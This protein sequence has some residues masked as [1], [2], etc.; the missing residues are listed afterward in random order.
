MKLSLI[1][2]PYLTHH[3][4]FLE[5]TK[6][7]S[8]IIETLKCILD[9][10]QTDEIPKKKLEE[11]QKL[12]SS[13]AP[14]TAE[15]KLLLGLCL[16]YGV[17]LEKNEKKA[18]E[19]FE[20]V[21]KQEH[22]AALYNLG[23]CY[24]DGI[25]VEQDSKQAVELYKCAAALEYPAAQNNLGYCYEK[26]K[27]IVCDNKQA[28]K[29]VELAA[30]SGFPT[31]LRNLGSYYENGEIVVQ[32]KK[33]AF[34][35]YVRAAE[36]EGGFPENLLNAARC[37]EDGVGV[38]KDKKRVFDYYMLAADR[39]SPKGY[40]ALSY[41]Y[42]SDTGVTTNAI[43][44]ILLLQ[45]LAKIGDKHA[46]SILL[47]HDPKDKK[48]KKIIEDFE[49]KSDEEA[50]QI[51]KKLNAE[52][53]GS[54]KAILGFFF[55]MGC[56]VKKDLKKA[57]EHYKIA[58]N[59]GENCNWDL[60]L[61]YRT[62]VQRGG[63]NNEL[64]EFYKQ[65]KISVDTEGPQTIVAGDDAAVET[66]TNSEQQTFNDEKTRKEN[67]LL[68]GYLYEYGAPDF[69]KN[70]R[71]SIEYY[72]KAKDIEDAYLNGKITCFTKDES[73][74][75]TYLNN[76]LVYYKPL[77]DLKAQVQAS[78]ASKALNYRIVNIV[79]EY[80]FEAPPVPIISHRL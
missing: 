8:L 33:R 36:A 64:L 23:K 78:D 68:L 62:Q 69:D 73:T 34:Y 7:D 76:K 41:Y 57:I 54:A 55:Q 47:N 44:S 51:I 2:I 26:G 15:E 11:I 6:A 67:A 50:E 31:A 71:K 18:F 22:P 43:R 13:N 53:T 27:G 37:Y 30:N 29:F 17:I 25:G 21:A 40:A 58:L 38:N 75:N 52:E 46:E 4:R 32:D 45:A 61:C 60:F 5:K 66:K 19:L 77:F 14:S 42:L 79:F 12:V 65:L 20:E 16:K 10:T 39:G 56:L 80:T 63:N 70:L 59:F 74:K 24:C 9:E 35:Y 72:S 3:L 49:T 1:T 48:I 28:L